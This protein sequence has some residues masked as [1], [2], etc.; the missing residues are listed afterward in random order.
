ME[1]MWHMSNGWGWWMAFG[2]AGMVLVLA[3][4]AWAVYAVVTRRDGR[5]D[6]RQ[7]DEP[8]PITILEGR[9]ACGDITAEQFVEMRGRLG[10]GDGPRTKSA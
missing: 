4:I 5:G 10:Y 2:W 8:E 7:P 6:Q 1:S 9:F 3:L